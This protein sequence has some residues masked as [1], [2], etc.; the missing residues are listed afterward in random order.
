MNSKNENKYSRPDG[1]RRQSYAK[2]DV[3]LTRDEDA[4]LNH[5]ADL[6][7]VTRSEILRKALVDFYKWNTQEE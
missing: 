7:D 6:N 3:R 2:C 1:I 5:L 4:M